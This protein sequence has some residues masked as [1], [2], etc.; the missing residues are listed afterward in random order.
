MSEKPQV[1]FLSGFSGSGKTET[2]K[3]LADAIAYQ[4]TDTD[5]VVE[6]ALGKSIPEIF[7]KM[8][9]S[10][11]R[12]AESNAIRIATLNKPQVIALGGGSI[13]DKNNLAY[14]K[15]MGF[16]IYMKVSPDAVFE[17]LQK[18]HFRPMLDTMAS[19]SDERIEEAKE[20]I[21]SLMETRE[22]FYMQADLVID[23]ENKS[24]SEVAEEIEAK[25]V[26]DE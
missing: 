25:L 24:P 9:E 15:S 10:K 22:K 14:V 7:A 16:M 8:G 12:F 26:A 17:R 13:A 18:S 6:D 11:F 2:G 4:F 20:R 1:I 21:K 23:T 3:L 19:G 5:S